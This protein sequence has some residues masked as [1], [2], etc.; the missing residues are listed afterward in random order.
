M[1]L[2]FTWVHVQGFSETDILHGFCIVSEQF[3]RLVIVRAEPI[4]NSHPFSWYARGTGR[5]ATQSSWPH[6]NHTNQLIPCLMRKSKHF[7]IYRTVLNLSINCLGFHS[8]RFIHWYYITSNSKSPSTLSVLI[9]Y[10]KTASGANRIQPACCTT[11]YISA[12]PMKREVRSG[13]NMPAARPHTAHLF[14]TRGL[15]SVRRPFRNTSETEGWKNQIQNSWSAASGLCRNKPAVDGRIRRRQL[16]F[17]S[18][19]TASLF[20]DIVWQWYN[21]QWFKVLSD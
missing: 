14:Q 21:K 16:R 6:H 7:F 9:W 12:I 4:H 10:T 8:L 5:R 18:F 2:G 19:I 20:N 3:I 17:K 15:F 1:L 11:S 13:L